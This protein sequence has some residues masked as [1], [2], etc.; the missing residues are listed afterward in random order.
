[1]SPEQ[2]R[3]DPGKIDVRT[4]V[5]TLGVILYE[6]LTERLPYEFENTAL[7]QAIRIICEESPKPPSRM[8]ERV[9]RPGEREDREN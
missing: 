5:Y 2:V 8:S 9:T 4:D 1:M 7:P 6:L 3:G